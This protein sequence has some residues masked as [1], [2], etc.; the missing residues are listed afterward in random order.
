MSN[1]PV[2]D[3]NMTSAIQMPKT[4]SVEGKLWETLRELAE[5]E[6]RIKLFSTLK[7]WGVATNDIRNVLFGKT[8]YQLDGPSIKP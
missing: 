5:T 2:V 7:S 8:T 1:N 3:L 6:G 4:K